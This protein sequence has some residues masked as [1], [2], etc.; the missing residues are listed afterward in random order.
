[1]TPAELQAWA[2]P[3]QTIWPEEKFRQ[4]EAK[5]DQQEE[6]LVSYLENTGRSPEDI[7]TVLV[8]AGYALEYQRTTEDLIDMA[9]A[10]LR[11]EGVA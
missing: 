5:R 1:M 11:R 10:I 3:E 6:I 8:E 7:D 4:Q 9:E 2:D